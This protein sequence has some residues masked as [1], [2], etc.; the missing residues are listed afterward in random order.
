LKNPWVVAVLN[1]LTFGGGTLLMGKR[2]LSAGLLTVGSLTFRYEEARQAPL[3][4]GHFD[5]H[6]VP[7]FIAMT[8]VGVG[9]A[10]DGYREAKGA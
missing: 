1:F 4:S 3:F 5:I 10:I 2:Q 9:C 8:L 6:W 7:L